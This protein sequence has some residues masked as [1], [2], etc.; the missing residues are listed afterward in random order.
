MPNKDKTK[1]MGD[2]EGLG[3]WDS[4]GKSRNEYYREDASSRKTL[5]MN[6]QKIRYG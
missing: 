1:K 2:D 4:L 6:R 3:W 5:S